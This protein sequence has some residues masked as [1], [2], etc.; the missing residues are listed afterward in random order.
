MILT[1][2]F[3]IVSPITYE[4]ICENIIDEINRIKI[5]QLKLSCFMEGK[6]LV[7]FAIDLKIHSKMSTG[8]PQTENL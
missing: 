3:D 8:S 2:P 4:I 6:L 1:E 5:S 7:D